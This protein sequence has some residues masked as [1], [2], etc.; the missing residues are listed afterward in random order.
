MTVGPAPAEL[1]SL[2]AGDHGDP[3]RVL[4]PHTENGRLVVRTLQPTARAVRV[5]IGELVV[6]ARRQG[7]DG[8]FTADCGPA[9]EN[10]AVRDELEVEC[11]GRWHRLADPFRFAPLLGPLDLHLFGEGRHRRLFEHLGAHPRT[12][13]GVEGTAFTVWAPNARGVRVVG[14]FNGWDGRG[15]PMRNVGG[16]GTYELF[17]PGVGRGTRYKFAILTRSGGWRLKADPFAFATE[18]PPRTASV[19]HGSAAA[20]DG[21]GWGD[22]DWLAARARGELLRRPLSVYEVHLGSWRRR[23]EEGDRPLTYRELAEPLADYVELMGFTHVELLPVA[24]HPLTASWGYQVTGYYA[25]TARYGGPDDFRALVDHLHRRGLGVIV[26]WVP[27]HFPRDDF[28]LARFD[29]TALYEHADPRQGTHPDWGTLIFN[30]GRNEV[31]NF[32]VANALFWFEAFHVDGLRVDAVASMLYLDYSRGEGQWVPNRYG[33]RENLDAIAF[34][35][36]LNGAVHAEHP[37]AL[38]IAEESTA[39]PGVSRPTHLGG[40]GFGYKWNMGWMHDTLEYFRHDPVH[41]R[42]HHNQLTFGLLYAW[43]ENF[44]L[45]LS[46]DEVVHGKRSLLGK[47]PGDRWQQFATL[48][49]LLAYMWAHPGKQLLFMG[50][51]FAQEREWDVG[52][53]LDWHLLDRPQHRGVQTLVHDLNRAYRELRSLWARDH[54]PDGFRWIDASDAD[55]NVIAFMR[56]GERG[57]PPLVCVGNFSP[58]PR[59]GYRLGLPAAGAW[60]ERLNTDSRHYGGSD[61]GN[62]GQVRAEPVASHGLPQSARLSLPPLATVWLVPDPGPGQGGASAPGVP[63]EEEGAGGVVTGG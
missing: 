32:L 17:V 35:Q 38:M 31:R 24:E 28:A 54:E 14:D 51:E 52:R 48:R 44:V 33:G 57:D 60:R 45:P 59:H 19:V 34:L 39:W 53:S 3:H 11:D 29:G 37:G 63:Q 13:D 12:V 20:P 47:M 21:P 5:R 62:L 2:V 8:L 6:A 55:A 22:Q 1:T 40:L 43:T 16:A 46:H 9:P 7:H 27:A 42:F 18:A 23:P 26:D 49:A 15:H 61:L 58:V 36:E 41:R 56:L 10:P 4:G 30:Y 50:G 25:P